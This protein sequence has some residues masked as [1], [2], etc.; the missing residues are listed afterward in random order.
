[1]GPLLFVLFFNDIDDTAVFCENGRFPIIKHQ[2]DEDLKNLSRWFEENELL[3]NLKPGK[4]ELL[5]FDTSQRIAKTN[6]NFKVKFNNQYINETK[7]YKYLGGEVDHTLNLNSY[8]DKTYKKM[9]SRLRLLNKLSSNITV[10]AAASIYNMVIVPLFSFCSLLKPTLTQTQINRI[11]SFERRV[12]EIIGY[13]QRQ[14][15][16]VNLINIQKQRISSFVLKVVMGEVDDPFE[17]YFGFSNTTINIRNKIILLPLL[18][19]KLEYGRRST[20][21]LGAKIFNDLPIEVLILHIVLYALVS[22][23]LFMYL[24]CPVFYNLR[25][26]LVIEWPARRVPEMCF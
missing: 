16:Q 19:L 21:Y 1:M 4:T 24:C 11:L 26:L 20:K 6:K 18:K 22:T 13:K 9:T 15:K 14:K 2:L 10:F 5:L 3:I 12:K 23:L 7:S 17:N 25:L 8:F